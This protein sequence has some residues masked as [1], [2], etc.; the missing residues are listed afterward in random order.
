MTYRIIDE[1]EILTLVDE[2]GYSQHCDKLGELEE[3]G[4]TYYLLASI[5]DNDVMMALKRVGD[6][7]ELSTID[8]CGEYS[9]I[10]DI[11]DLC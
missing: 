6:E 11:F 4:I 5:E 3:N 2:D 7:S 9:R 1:D 8:D 10:A